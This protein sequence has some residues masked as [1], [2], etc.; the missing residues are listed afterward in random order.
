MNTRR[1]ISSLKPMQA[2]VCSR[3]I[4]QMKAFVPR[5]VPNHIHF[6]KRMVSERS[7][8]EERLK[9][10]GETLDPAPVEDAVVIDFSDIDTPNARVK[11][12]V[13]EVLELNILEVNMFFKTIQ[14]IMCTYQ[15]L[16]VCFL[17]L[18]VHTETIRR[19]G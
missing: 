7:F 14:V 2:R 5:T 4:S 19:F 11:R 6:A 13:D 18:R 12:I 3:T 1:L 17:K 15:L 9:E 16:P 8:A 10:M